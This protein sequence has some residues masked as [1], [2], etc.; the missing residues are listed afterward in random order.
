MQ[1]C[2]VKA[3]SAVLVVALLSEAVVLQ[4]LVGW[5]PEFGQRLRGAA[6]TS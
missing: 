5:V 1:V 2:T 4:Q 3:P 6:V